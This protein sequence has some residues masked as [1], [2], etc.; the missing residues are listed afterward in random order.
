[1][2]WNVFIFKFL[3]FL[4]VGVSLEEEVDLIFLRGPLRLI[5][6]A[7]CIL[8][9]DPLTVSWNIYLQSYQSSNI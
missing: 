8:Y 6:T 2:G 3:I 9:G 4:T 5:T 1:M 7:G